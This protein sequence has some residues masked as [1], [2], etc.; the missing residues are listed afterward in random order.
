MRSEPR[1]GLVALA[2]AATLIGCG[3]VLRL[4][5]RSLST[6]LSLP[7]A[8]LSSLELRDVAVNEGVTVV[9]GADDVNAEL[10]LIDFSARPDS[11]RVELVDHSGVASL[12][13]LGTESLSLVRI[14]LRVPS[15]LS[16]EL[17]LTHGELSLRD[18]RAPAVVGASAVTLRNVDAPVTVE[19]GS[20]H[21]D[22]DLPLDLM[23]AED[24][25]GTLRRGGVVHTRG[26]AQITLRGEHEFELVGLGDDPSG[27]LE[28]YLPAAARTTLVVQT[29]GHAVVRVGEL[30]YDSTTEGAASASAGLRFDL[31][32]G[33][34]LVTLRARAGSIL[35]HASPSP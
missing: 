18:L 5:A 9:G 15:R 2:C 19:R 31:N 7:G 1:V 26:N 12:Q 29:P 21:V 11:A 14:D 22:Y 8:G 32:G 3:T 6:E 28:V 16:T 25:F 4:D 17:E 35:V 20:T 23:A 27:Y 34:P 24:V 33:G 30:D 13:M 10:E